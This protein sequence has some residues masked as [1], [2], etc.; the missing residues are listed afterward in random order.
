MAIGDDL[1]KFVGDT[2]PNL[3][4]TDGCITSANDYFNNCFAWAAGDKENRW[5]IGPPHVWFT[6]STA[7]TLENYIENY[8][9][10]GFEETDTPEFEEGFEKVAIYVDEDGEPLHAARLM[11]NGNWTSKLG[12][13]EDME[14]QTLGCLECD[15]YGTA[16]AFLKRP[17]GNPEKWIKTAMEKHLKNLKGLQN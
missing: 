8:G 5:Q 14:H 4:A 10:V 6:A 16:K 12:E 15:D 13:L 7:E 2:F 1:T 9:Y 11:E 3:L 17:R